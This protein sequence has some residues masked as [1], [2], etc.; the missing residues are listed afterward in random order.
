MPD[1]CDPMDCS[2]QGFSAHGISQAR[3]LDRLPFP[4]PGDLPHPGGKPRSPALQVDS[5][6]TEPPGKPV[7][8]I[9][10]LQFRLLCSKSSSS[11]V[12]NVPL[13]WQELYPH[14]SF[15]PPSSPHS[16]PVRAQQM[17]VW[18]TCLPLASM[19]VGAMWRFLRIDLILESLWA[20][21]YSPGLLL[22]F[23]FSLSPVRE[24]QRS[25]AVTSAGCQMSRTKDATWWLFT[26]VLLLSKQNRCP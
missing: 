2:P 26:S 7:T 12:R 22:A 21:A 20:L 18:L 9:S 16:C 19:Q 6:L 13:Q 24:P 11:P 4:F 17:W 1:F 5:L 3:I 15:E 8:L 10:A 25:V 14:D 23:F